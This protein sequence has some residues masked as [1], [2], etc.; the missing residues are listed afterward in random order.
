MSNLDNEPVR[1]TGYEEKM[2]PALR[3]LARAAIELARQQLER[4]KAAKPEEVSQPAASPEQE[5]DR[6]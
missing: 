3:R 5:A 6:G 1:V 4:Q 2:H